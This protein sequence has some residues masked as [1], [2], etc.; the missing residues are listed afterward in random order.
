[1]REKGHLESQEGVVC[2]HLECSLAKLKQVASA[3]HKLVQL[4]VG[5]HSQEEE[6]RAQPKQPCVSLSDDS[7]CVALM[8]LSSW[9]QA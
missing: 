7:F 5:N 4:G 9:K 6:E 8:K 1:M 2:C 3:E